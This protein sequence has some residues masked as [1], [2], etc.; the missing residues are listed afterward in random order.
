[1][2]SKSCLLL[3]LLLLGVAGYSTYGARAI[4]SH[5]HSTERN[6]LDMSDWPNLSFLI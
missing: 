5:N 4:K 6:E 2:F 3:P 1:M